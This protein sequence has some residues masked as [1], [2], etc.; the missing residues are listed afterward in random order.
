MGQKYTYYGVQVEPAF[1]DRQF[2]YL[3]DEDYSVNEYVVV[4]FGRKQLLGI[5]SEVRHCTA[6]DAP[7]PPEKTKKIIRKATD[8]DIRGEPEPGK[9]DNTDDSSW[10]KETPPRVRCNGRCIE[11]SPLEL[12]IIQWIKD[13]QSPRPLRD[14]QRR[15]RKYAPKAVE[16]A[17]ERLLSL[18]I[19]YGGKNFVMN[20]YFPNTEVQIQI[21]GTISTE[22]AN[23]ETVFRNASQKEIEGIAA[24]AVAVL[25]DLLGVFGKNQSVQLIMITAKY[26]T[27]H[28]GMLTE[29]ENRLVHAV[30]D[31]GGNHQ[32][33]EMVC[34]SM[35]ALPLEGLSDAIKILIKND[36]VAM[37]V[38]FLILSFAYI[39]GEIDRNVAEELDGLYDA[40]MLTRARAMIRIGGKEEKSAGGR[41][42]VP[43]EP[44]AQHQRTAAQKK[45]GAEKGVPRD[46][47]KQNSS[48]PA[49]EVQA[50]E[51][52]AKELE[53]Q[54]CHLYEIQMAEW[55]SK[56]EEIIKKRNAKVQERLAQEEKRLIAEETA[57]GNRAI[58]RLEEEVRRLEENV[59]ASERL[60]ASLGILKFREKKEQKAAIEIANRRL[61]ETHAAL[62]LEKHRLDRL[63]G[64]AGD[65]ARRES[66][67]FRAEAEKEFPIPPKPEKPEAVKK[68]EAEKK[69]KENEPPT[70]EEQKERIVKCLRK[71]GSAT[72]DELVE[73]DSRLRKLTPMKLRPALNELV[74]TGIVSRGENRGKV[75][76]SLTLE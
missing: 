6:Q 25:L 42:R 41:K 43:E 26:G 31:D 17:M 5:I 67:S 34:Q 60:L 61:A 35:G 52:K 72:L 44:A 49:P 69:R 75:I 13:D 47:R 62:S 22:F 50:E 19:L 11:V 38:L 12:K 7:Y 39:D 20:T 36:R 70:Y 15:Y 28:G 29:R 8:D 9:V 68:R 57:R 2:Y 73:N 59:K 56:R 71:M 30:F 18:G 24:E 27:G 74:E 10:K 48:Q 21:P 1:D 46:D 14:V 64:N 53:E 76:F 32:T 16:E 66:S 58:E 3:A 54:E 4:P 45:T 33:L 51:R 40:D 63:I 65:A 37:Y 23:L 55:K